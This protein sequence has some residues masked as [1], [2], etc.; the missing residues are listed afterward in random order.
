MGI[1]EASTKTT[2]DMAMW[3]FLSIQE[4][5]C[6]GAWL[7]P[8]YILLFHLNLI[9]SKQAPPRTQHVCWQLRCA[10]CSFRC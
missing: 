4:L 5:I 8:T 1:G 2:G 3:L 10:P 7:H 9:T 6:A